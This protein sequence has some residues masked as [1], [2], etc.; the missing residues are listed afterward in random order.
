MGEELKGRLSWLYTV[1]DIMCLWQ[2]V[3]TEFVLQ[4]RGLHGIDKVVWTRTDLNDC[5]RGNDDGI[6]GTFP[7]FKGQSRIFDDRT[8]PAGNE[9]VSIG[10]SDKDHNE[11]TRELHL[12]ISS[13]IKIINLTKIH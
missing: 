2:S 7:R 12:L 1:T 9:R 13:S 4:E 3:L 11:G 10:G 8:T 5:R 6:L